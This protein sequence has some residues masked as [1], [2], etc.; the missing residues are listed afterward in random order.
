MD[1]QQRLDE[2]AAKHEV[3]GAAVAVLDGDQISEAAY[4]ITNRNT[5]VEVT[6]DTIFQIGSITKVYT[7]TLVMQL[8]DE[9]RVDLD[10]PVK[11]YLPDLRLGDAE[12]TDVVTVRQFLCHTAGLEGDHFEDYGRGDDAI[13]RYVESLAALPQLHQPGELMSYCNAGWVLL[14]RLVEQVA[15]LPYHVVLRERLLAPAG[16]HDTVV[17]P[18]DAILRRVAVGH[19]PN[20]EGGDP[21][22]APMWT[23]SPAS[24]PAGSLP[25][26]TARDLVGFARLHLDEGRAPDGTQVLS[27]ASVKAMQ[28]PQVD[29]PDKV[30]LGDAWGLGWILF[31]WDGRRLIGHDGGTIGQAA[32]L[33]VGPERRFAVGLLT[34]GGGAG[35]LY[36][37]LYGELFASELGIDL[38]PQ[39]Q[40]LADAS[41]VDLSR[42]VGT[43]QRHNV[44]VE[45]READGEL[46]ADMTLEGP[47]AAIRPAQKDLPVKPADES[48]F[49]L[50]ST[51]RGGGAPSPAVFFAFDEDGR[52]GWLHFGARAHR[53][54]S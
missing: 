7:A 18:E 44:T 5:G 17:L 47:L 37:E 53:R 25:C 21:L 11:A 10:Q 34:N 32:F 43:Y 12:A 52:P 46:R 13:Q 45:V 14:G 29:L 27:P 38:P 6:T 23:L 31:A 39:P 24:A 50:Y 20:P 8:V 22:V 42:Y 1:L 16:L 54:V 3:V 4:G 36:R 15:A 9:G 28:Q 35:E 33:R 2:L 48:V 30:T 49:L 51:L 26:A 41:A 19:M 40:A